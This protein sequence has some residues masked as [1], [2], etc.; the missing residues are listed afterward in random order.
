MQPRLK[1]NIYTALL[2]A[3]PGTESAP[4]TLP[5]VALPGHKVEVLAACRSANNVLAA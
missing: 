2:A 3:R 4:S 5:T 1:V